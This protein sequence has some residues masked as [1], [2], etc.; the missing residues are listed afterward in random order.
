MLQAQEI[1]YALIVD[2]S[3]RT[4]LIY[5]D[6]LSERPGRG[7]NRPELNFIKMAEFPLSP[8]SLFLSGSVSSAVD[9]NVIMSLGTRHMYN[10]LKHSQ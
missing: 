8:L 7:T 6:S 9:Q 10:G 3:I 5:H 2:C 4:C 1:C